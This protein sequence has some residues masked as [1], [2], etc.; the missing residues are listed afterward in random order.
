MSETEKKREYIDMTGMSLFNVVTKQEVEIIG[1]CGSQML[2]CRPSGNPKTLGPSFLHI[3]SLGH[4][5]IK[6]EA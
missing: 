5:G 4:W 3:G 6:S 2:M 1:Y